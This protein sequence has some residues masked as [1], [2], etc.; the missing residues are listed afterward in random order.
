MK[1]MNEHQAWLYYRRFH[2]F[3]LREKPVLEMTRLLQESAG[4]DS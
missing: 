1:M 2:I 4:R 3:N